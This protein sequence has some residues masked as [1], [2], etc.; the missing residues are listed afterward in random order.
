[1]TFGSDPR[2]ATCVLD[3]PTVSALHA[4]LTHTAEGE[5]I[6]ADAGSVAGTWVN[7]TPASS[8]GVRLMHGDLI[9]IGRVTLRFELK[10]KGETRKITV[11]PY[12]EEDL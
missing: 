12:D 4:R 8:V 11:T 7:Y 9:H 5:F 6:L 3:S 2:Q 10:T 1:M